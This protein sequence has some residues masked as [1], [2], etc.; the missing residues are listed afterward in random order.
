MKNQNI[1]PAKRNETLTQEF[2]EMFE[3]FARDFFSPELDESDYGFRPSVQVEETEKGYTVSAELPGMVESDIKLSLKDNSLVIEGKKEAHSR[4]DN[5]G[6]F[7]S[8]FSYG[9]FY[10]TI[11]LRAD[12]DNNN[13]VAQYANGVLKVE[14]IKKADGPDKSHR[15]LINEKKH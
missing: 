10:R 7:R 14:L 8:E 4:S 6:H 2:G 5:S 12:I 11:P 3:R 13:I 1:L 15:I 9:S